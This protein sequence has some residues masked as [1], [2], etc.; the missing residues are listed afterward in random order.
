MNQLT[1]EQKKLIIEA[2]DS[3]TQLTAIKTKMAMD[4]T[5]K[6]FSFLPDEV[7]NELASNLTEN[8][9]LKHNEMRAEIEVIKL[10]LSM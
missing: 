2:L 10:K 3:H 1:E 5:R 8:E 6:C 9:S 4:E 7:L